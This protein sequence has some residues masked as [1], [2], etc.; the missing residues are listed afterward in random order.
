MDLTN[1]LQSRQILKVRNPQH[2]TKASDW[3]A[4]QKS[5]FAI[6]I[7]YKSNDAQKLKRC[8]REAGYRTEFAPEYVF[9]GKS[10]ILSMRGGVSVHG[11]KHKNKSK[12]YCLFSARYL[13]HLG[14]V[15]RYT[16]NLAKELTIKGNKVLIV[17]SLIGNEVIYEEKEEGTIF[18]IPSFKVLNGRF[19]I[20][21][22]NN[23]TKKLLC[24]LNN[25]SIDAIII[26]TRF[27]SLSYVGAKFAKRNRIDAIVVEH[28]TGHFT[29]NNHFFDFAGHIY[30]HIISKLIKGCGHNFYGVSLECNKWLKH[31][32][33]IASGVLYNAVDANQIMVLSKMPCKILEEVIQYQ[34]NDIIISFT[35]RIIKE[36][37]VLKLISAFQKVKEKYPNAK[38]CIAGDGD[39]YDS[40][41][42]KQYDSIY[43]LGQLPFDQV[44]A[45]LNLTT[46][47]CLP[48]DYPE[49]L[50]TSILEAAICKNYVITTKSGGAKEV[51]PD[52]S[53]GVI[54]ERNDIEEIYTKLMEA[55]DDAKMRAD[56][57]KRLYD[58]VINK[59]TWSNTAN[60][61]IKIFEGQTSKQEEI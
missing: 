48:T 40:L 54:M 27:Y 46:V 22:F 30:E 59:F 2:L 53:Y 1:I 58:R 11:M 10:G 47:F 13:P 28:G 24:R 35:G 36:K 32:N 23:T 52:R 21:K 43:L 6:Y 39:L 12:T 25:Y 44:I 31:F 60:Q 41:L 20:I 8:F 15:E 57:S 49:G 5:Q 42:H 37:G 19:P 38:L 26:N 3:I 55:L 50:P 56:V 29:V 17:T 18:R 51:I 34:D 45:L 14:G 9:I 7:Y 16:Y 61:L 33:I 4:S